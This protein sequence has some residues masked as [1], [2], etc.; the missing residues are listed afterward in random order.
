MDSHNLK[1]GN[2]CLIC[3]PFASLL[4]RGVDILEENILIPHMKRCYS[5]LN[6]L[7][8]YKKKKEYET[9]ENVPMTIFI[10]IHKEKIIV[11][12]TSR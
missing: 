8:V 11:M 4:V 10:Y 7:I 2:F 3:L 1:R 5:P 12:E 9:F 6:H